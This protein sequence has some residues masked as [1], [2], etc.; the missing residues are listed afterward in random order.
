LE[1]RGFS[2]RA[3]LPD[4]DAVGKCRFQCRGYR[5]LGSFIGLGYEIERRRFAAN[6]CRGELAESRH[7]LGPSCEC[8]DFPDGVNVVERERHVVFL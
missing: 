7:D 2:V 5:D 8:E 3:L 6:L 4:D 1:K